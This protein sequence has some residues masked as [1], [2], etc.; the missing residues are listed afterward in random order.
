MAKQYRNYTPNKNIN[1]DN[2]NTLFNLAKTKNLFFH[3]TSTS[4]SHNQNI[5]EKP[6]TNVPSLNV[7]KTLQSMKNPA[8]SKDSSQNQSSDQIMDN[9]KPAHIVNLNKLTP[10]NFDKIKEMKEGKQIPL[11]RN[12]TNNKISSRSKNTERSELYSF[13]NQPKEGIQTNINMKRT[14]DD[15]EDKSFEDIYDLDDTI[16]SQI[17]QLDDEEK[18]RHFTKLD[19]QYKFF[20]P[21]QKKINKKKI[22]NS[23]LPGIKIESTYPKESKKILEYENRKISPSPEIKW[24][25]NKKL[26]NQ[27]SNNVAGSSGNTLI[28][29]HP[30]SNQLQSDI[31]QKN[32]SAN[33]TSIKFAF[34]SSIKK[35]K[36]MKLVDIYN[37]DKKKWV[38]KETKVAEELLNNLR[39]L[40]DERK[41]NFKILSS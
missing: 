33:A 23:S 40:N 32:F 5:S 14:I 7:I 16:D 26:Y 39:N 2:D 15:C 24:V 41:S 12:F 4:S 35:P 27:S 8:N 1:I 31:Q 17:S 11:S 13:F 34:N 25:Q 18:V 30:F 37:Y 36:K 3:M 9:S 38:D 6:A 21:V 20:F 10:L 29:F 28:N 19:T 22:K